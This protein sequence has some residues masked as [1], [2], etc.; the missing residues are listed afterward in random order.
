M[1]CEVCGKETD[2]G[3]VCSSTLG[4]ASFYYCANCLAMGFEPYDDLVSTAWC[5]GNYPD[6]CAPWFVELIKRE[7]LFF[8]K[9]E[10][11][12]KNDINKLT[13]SYYEYIMDT[14]GD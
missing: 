1:K 14:L 13:K 9:T 8:G 4:G 7:L 12:F 3:A 2:N 5:V 11:D 10:E 6:D